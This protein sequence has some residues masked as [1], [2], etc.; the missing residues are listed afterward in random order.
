MYF[1]KEFTNKIFRLGFM[2]VVL[3][4]LLDLLTFF[5]YPKTEIG[6]I[7][8]ATREQTPLTWVSAVILL[9]IALTCATKYFETKSRLWYFFSLAFLFFSMD[10]AT[11]FHERFSGAIQELIPVFRNFPSYS[12]ILLYFPLLFFGIGGLI[13]SLW[14]S[15]QVNVKKLL[16]ISCI[17]L[18]VSLLLDMIDGW[19]IKDLTLVFHYNPRID[20]ATIHIIRLIEETFEV[21]GFGLLAYLSINRYASKKDLD[22]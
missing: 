16:I 21:F 9:F 3:L 2:F 7:F 5:Y 15:A 19:V 14:K 11:Y 1:A 6:K 20:S 12:W 18:S 4:V 13:I 10:D 17:L 8:L 22:L